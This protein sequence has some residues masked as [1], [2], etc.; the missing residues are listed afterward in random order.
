MMACVEDVE[1]WE[2]SQAGDAEAFA[3][4]FDRHAN[5]VYRHCFRCVADWALAEDL[6]SV[7]FLEAWRRRQNVRISGASVR[8][9]LLGVAMNVVRNQQRAL[10][11]YRAALERLPP[12]GPTHDFSDRLVES[13]DAARRMRALS[14]EL[15]QLPRRERE[16]LLLS[17]ADLTSREIATALGI[18]E[19]TVRTRMARA[20]RRLT[21]DAVR[22]S[23]GLD[24]LPQE[25]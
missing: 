20:R 13:M 8:P 1:L 12:P 15:R 9:W 4:L 21:S 18:P 24:W 23:R 2:R 3:A 16:V 11:R 5:T 25:E 10:R 7:V 22:A 17:W 6:T 14:R 19:G